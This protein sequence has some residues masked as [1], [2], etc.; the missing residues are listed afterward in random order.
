[1][2]DTIYEIC[3]SYTDKQDLII[4]PFFKET[5]L[6][7]SMPCVEASK[8][9]VNVFST[10]K[11][12]TLPEIVDY[13][14]QL[15]VISATIE[16]GFATIGKVGG[17][18]NIGLDKARLLGLENII[19]QQMPAIMMGAGRSF[20]RTYMYNG[21]KKFCVNNAAD[22][23]TKGGSVTDNAN[24]SMIGITWGKGENCGI[25]Q[26]AMSGAKMFD[27]YAIG[28]GNIIYVDNERGEKIAGY[29]LEIVTY[30]GIQLP[31]KDRVHAFVNID[32]SHLPSAEDL[33]QFVTKFN[34]FDSDSSVIYCHP[35]LFVK[36]VAKFSQEQQRNDVIHAGQWN[37]KNA[38]FVVNCPIVMDGNML[39]GTEALVP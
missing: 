11:D 15:P 1:M 38:I 3:Q 4:D 22:C 13:D 26:P 8:G 10:V 14:A 19:N 6:F 5:P 20:D 34:G 28:G 29:A 21:L 2:K 39:P 33:L 23:L 27:R 12:Y 30:I 18:M 37:G 31:R 9:L 7:N 24:F 35:L 17:R 25:Y 36:L 32:N 16:T